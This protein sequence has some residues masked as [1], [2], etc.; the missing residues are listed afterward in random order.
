MNPVFDIASRF[1]CYATDSP[2]SPL[3]NTTNNE[4]QNNPD[5]DLMSR[6]GQKAKSAAKQ[7]VGGVSI[8]GEAGYSAFQNYFTG[9]SPDTISCAQ[10]GVVIIQRVNLDPFDTTEFAHFK[11]HKH[12]IANITFNPA[13]TILLTAS[14]KGTTI[15]V[16]SIIGKGSPFKI[17]KFSRGLTPADVTNLHLSADDEWLFCATS[18]GTLHIFDFNS[19][20][21][22]KINSRNSYQV[23]KSL[24]SPDASRDPSAS[25][26]KFKSSSMDNATNELGYDDFFVDNRKNIFRTV[27]ILENGTDH[28][29]TPRT[30]FFIWNPFGVLSMYQIEKKISKGE[31]DSSAKVLLLLN[32]KGPTEWNACRPKDW[33]EIAFPV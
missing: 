29:T 1:L 22:I 27:S 6:A 24:L 2:L 23:V 21:S 25:S 12:P 9:V 14:K 4:N 7:F 30:T 31:I 20:N 32:R 33:D 16:W 5:I 15:Y 10:D 13:G 17:M 18:R 26:V 19:P 8:V 11:A 3:S 28:Q